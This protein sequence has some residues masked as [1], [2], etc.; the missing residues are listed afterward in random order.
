[1]FG[2][3]LQLAR[4][5]AGLSLRGLADALGGQVTA[6]AI[7]KY[8]RGEMM[9]SSTVLLAL[10]KALGVSMEFLA[11]PLEVRLGSI[12][13]RKKAG[14]RARDRALVEAL[15]LEHVERY[16]LVEEVLELETA[17]WTAPFPAV[18]VD[19][20]E[21]AE[22]V[23]GKLRLTWTLG[24][25]PIP[26]VTELLEEKGI[27]VMH[28]PLPDDV[29]GLTCMI[30]RDNV[31][32]VPV[33][34]VNSA[35]GL[36]RRRLTLVHEL[37]HRIMS[38]AGVDEEKAANRFASAFLMPAPHIREQVGKHRNGF[39]VAELMVTKRLYAVSAA[40]LLVRLRDLG[41]ITQ[42]T[43][44]Y[45]FQSFGR[46]W[47][48]TEPQPIVTTDAHPREQ[49]QRFERLCYRALSEG[50]ITI[51]KAAELLG[52]SVAVIDEE[53]R[54]AAVTDRRQ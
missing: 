54:G 4:K 32:P 37:A 23:A 24:H 50:L 18:A 48:K 10:T 2:E 34:V 53:M 43:M 1:M 27:K 16:L 14:T 28:L 47:R 40:A 7:G 46:T 31:S 9:P 42:Q 17:A 29:S 5:K 36:E 8:E 11:A 51:S 49:P 30:E 44:V 20:L 12:D 21:A 13:F 35:H 39:G 33:I 52:K 19:S 22:E 6:Q 15:V 38:V 41:I 3:R 26:D 45:A 25:D